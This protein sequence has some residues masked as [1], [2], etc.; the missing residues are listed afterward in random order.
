MAPAC[1]AKAWNSQY[2]KPDDGI[3]MPHWLTLPAESRFVS[4]CA[5]SSCS[6]QVAGGFS[7]SRPASLNRSLFQYR[8]IVER[9]KGTPQVPPPVWLFSMK[10]GKKLLIQDLS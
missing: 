4:F 3:W 6:C 5:N 2:G 9:W 7:G 8:T 1:V 10:A